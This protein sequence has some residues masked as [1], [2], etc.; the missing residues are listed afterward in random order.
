[1]LHF[2]VADADMNSFLVSMFVFVHQDCQ[3]KMS[4]NLV[5]GLKHF[6]FYIFGMVG[7]VTSIFQR[8]EI[9]N[10]LYTYQ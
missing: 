8:V 7:V 5:G 6:Y 2:L 10:Q 1:M 3:D 9:T 4:L